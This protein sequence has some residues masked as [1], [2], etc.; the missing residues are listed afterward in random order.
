MNT[1]KQI[2]NF[3]KGLILLL[4]VGNFASCKNELD[5]YA[6]GEAQPII[7]G[8]LNPYDSVQSFRIIKSFAGEGDPSEYAQVPDSSYFRDVD[9]RLKELQFGEVTNSWQLIETTITNKESGDFF[10]PEQK[11]YTVTTTKSSGSAF[12]IN[13]EAEFEL[14]GTLDGREIGGKFEIVKEKQ[15]RAAFF[16]ADGN[17]FARFQRRG[18]ITIVNGDEPNELTF[19]L[20]YPVGTK[21]A[22]LKLVFTYFE[23]YAGEEEAVEKQIEFDLGEQIIDNAQEPKQVSFKFSGARFYERIGSGIE[24]IADVKNLLFRKTGPVEFKMIAVSEDLFY[25]RQVKNTSSGIAQDR[26]EY[27][28][29]EN[30][31]GVLAGRQVVTMSE[32]L[33]AHGFPPIEVILSKFTEKELVTGLILGYTGGKGFCADASHNLGDITC[34]N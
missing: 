19:D 34:D 28:N 21:V 32:Q 18:D 33:V 17:N 11:I 10:G 9:V 26:P 20:D 27:T 2:S 14:E 7:Y 31:F 29:V 6:D 25:Y 12:Y 23:T 24:D 4:V 3:V 15:G 1:R 22:G 13:P 8:V 5:I 30:G 16:M